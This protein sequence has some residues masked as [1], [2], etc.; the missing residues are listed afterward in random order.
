MARKTKAA[1]A[2]SENSASTPTSQPDT[3]APASSDTTGASTA[4]TPTSAPSPIVDK[5]SG[6]GKADFADDATYEKN[7]N[8]LSNV[9][10]PTGEEPYP[11]T[12]GTE[13]DDGW[14]NVKIEHVSL[15]PEPNQKHLLQ[16]GAQLRMRC[17]V[18]AQPMYMAAAMT[19]RK[20]LQDAGYTFK[21]GKSYSGIEKRIVIAACKAG[22][23][24]QLMED[25]A[26]RLK[27]KE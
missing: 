26:E 15:P 2:S 9:R 7:P 21:P 13:K 6:R 4:E 24:T 19:A 11:D 1:V 27:V 10:W 3:K 16:L 25:F 14:V 18:C 20:A 17:H 12:P 5:R 8:R 22:H 23:T